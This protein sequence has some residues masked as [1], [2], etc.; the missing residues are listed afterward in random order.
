MAFVVMGSTGKS[1]EY[2]DWI[3]GAAQSEEAAQAAV[4]RLTDVA[5]QHRVLRPEKL[6]NGFRLDYDRLDP[7]IAALKEAGDPESKRIDCFTGV[8]YEYKA[9][10]SFD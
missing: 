9:V 6:P 8:K 4:A 7:A 2:Q 10:Q 3:V 5:K 1:G